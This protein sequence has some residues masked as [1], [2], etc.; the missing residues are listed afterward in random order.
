MFTFTITDKTFSDGI[1]AVAVTFTDED[2]TFIHTF[3]TTTAN[4][5]D[6]LKKAI[7]AKLTD[8]DTLSDFASSLKKGKYNTTITPVVVTPSP[9]DQERADFFEKKNKLRATRDL[10]DLGIIPQDDEEYQ[11]LLTEAKEAFDSSY[12]R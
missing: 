7:N 2:N 9:V 10:I 11:T 12:I 5:A 6:W 4:D 8:L 1:L 3:T